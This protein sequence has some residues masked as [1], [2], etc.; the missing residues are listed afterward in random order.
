[1]QINRWQTLPCSSGS[2][3]IW[4]ASKVFTGEEVVI[5]RVADSGGDAFERERAVLKVKGRF[6]LPLA[7]IS[8]Y[9]GNLLVVDVRFRLLIP[10]RASQVN[11]TPRRRVSITWTVAVGHTD[12]G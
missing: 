3:E 8:R 6:L 1:M 7:V 9:P 4:F 11:R 2:S 5:K 10:F 12:D